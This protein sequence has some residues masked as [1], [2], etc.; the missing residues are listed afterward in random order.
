MCDHTLNTPQYLLTTT[1]PKVAY[2]CNTVRK[3]G[4]VWV[5]ANPQ[6]S[7]KIHWLGNK[8]ISQIIFQVINGFVNPPHQR[9]VSVS[10]CLF[11]VIIYIAFIV[12]VVVVI[13]VVSLASAS[14]VPGSVVSYRD[15]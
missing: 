11:T 9:L 6:H 3:Y 2:F 15:R 8:A 1:I 7:T 4:G 13:V 5:S 14:M 10:P 12:A